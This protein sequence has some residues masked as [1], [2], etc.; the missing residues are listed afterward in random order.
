MKTTSLRTVLVCGLLFSPLMIELRAE[1]TEAEAREFAGEIWDFYEERDFDEMYDRFHS[2][3]QKTMSRS[4]WLKAARDMTAK[5]GRT[6]SRT[7][8]DTQSSW[9]SI[10]FKYQTKYQGGR[11][12]DTLG[13]MEE[14]GVLTVSGILVQP[15]L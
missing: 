2:E 14:D 6:V 7:L 9:G 13:V 4:Q 10:I 5:S 3:F 1:L 12:I 11:A 15:Q 8:A